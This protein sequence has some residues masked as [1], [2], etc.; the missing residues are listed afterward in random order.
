MSKNGISFKRNGA[1]KLHPVRKDNCPEGSRKDE[2][3]SRKKQNT[4]EMKKRRKVRDKR[5]ILLR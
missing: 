3:G 1:N 2:G 5:K 4:G